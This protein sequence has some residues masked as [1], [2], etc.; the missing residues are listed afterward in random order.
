MQPVFHAHYPF[1]IYL[2][3]RKNCIALVAGSAT[4]QLVPIICG[5]AEVMGTQFPN[6]KFVD[7]CNVNPADATGHDMVKFALEIA[8]A[9]VGLF[10]LNN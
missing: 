8:S 2:D 10:V 4:C 7:D 3:K 5:A 6:A 9:A 1:E